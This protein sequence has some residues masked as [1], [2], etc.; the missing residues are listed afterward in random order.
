MLTLQETEQLHKL[1]EENSYVNT[2]VKKLLDSHQYTL[3][4][5]SHELRNPLTMISGTLQLIEKQHP[6]VSTYSHWSN[7]IEDIDY[8]EK[9]LEDLSLYNNGTRLNKQL[10]H[11]SDFFSHTALSFASSITEFPIE[12]TSY[13][14]QDLPD[15]FGDPIKLRQLFLNL[16]RN[17]LEAIACKGSIQLVVAHKANSIIITISDDG[18]G[19]PKERLSDIFT[20][21][22]TYKSNG[23][24]LGL[25]ISK[26]IVTAHKG[27]IAVASTPLKGT[28]FTIRLPI[29]YRSQT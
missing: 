4:R 10:I 15:F 6:E 22:T 3:S 29:E 25:A 18:C 5:I 28:T 2:L 20:P 24:G 1:M 23:T 13:I 17:S 16:L 19:I 8:M 14:P 21:F 27:T 7:I 26:A 9:L 12:F 11:T